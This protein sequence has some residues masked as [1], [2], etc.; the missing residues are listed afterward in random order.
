RAGR[1][2][3]PLP[4]HRRRNPSHCSSTVAD[5]QGDTLKPFSKAV[6]LA[7]A[8]VLAPGFDWSF[9]TNT[10]PRSWHSQTAFYYI[11][12]FI[13]PDFEPAID[14]G[15]VTW[16]AAG[17][18]WFFTPAQI[19]VDARYDVGDGIS[20]I[21]FT[22]PFDPSAKG[23]T[24]VFTSGNPTEIVEVDTALNSNLPWF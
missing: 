16:N 19:P 14:Q 9:V 3:I 24:R 22:T 5:I 18:A 11:S 13:P 12:D 23:E 2:D 21:D 4:G 1:K 7:V 8:I 10:P 17:A 15:A 20:V 6:L